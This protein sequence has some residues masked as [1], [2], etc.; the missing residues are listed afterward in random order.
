MMAPFA[1]PLNL[2]LKT[3]THWF[4]DRTNV[5]KRVGQ[6]R[7][8][9]L[10]R[11]GAMVR[12][13]A[14]RSIRKSKGTSAPGEPPKSHGQH[15]LR[16]KIFYALDPRRND[17]VIGPVKLNKPGTAPA[18]LEHGGTATVMK[19]RHVRDKTTKVVRRVP[20]EPKEVVIEP[21]PYM[22]PALVK[23]RP[24]LSRLWASTVTT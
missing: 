4:F 18:T 23:V 12:L 10:N 17:V 15:L 13:T 11:A 7:A 22:G 2:K 9:F 21:R 24:Q 19:Y 8:R 6:Q 5:I 1:S 16:S 3:T 20:V 14:R